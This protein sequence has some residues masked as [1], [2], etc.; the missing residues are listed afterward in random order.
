M[1]TTMKA[2]RRAPK[3][4]TISHRV[5]RAKDVY[6]R[7]EFELAPGSKHNSRNQKHNVYGPVEHHEKDLDNGKEDK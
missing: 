2:V 4:R 7:R 6:P 5:Q 1:L 3:L